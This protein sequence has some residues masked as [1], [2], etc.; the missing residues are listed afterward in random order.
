[1]RPSAGRSANGSRPPRAGSRRQAALASRKPSRVEALTLLC[2]TLRQTID[3]ARATTLE[4]LTRRIAP[5]VSALLPGAEVFCDEKF[6]VGAVTRGTAQERFELLSDGT[7]E[8]IAVLAR[9][10]LADLLL[11][12]GRPAS[13]VLDDALAFSDPERIERMFDI[14]HRAAARMQIIV[15]TCRDDVFGRLGGRRLELVKPDDRSPVP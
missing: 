10:A 15:L 8:Q 12:A 9:I 13:I 5:L 1:M 3:R 14:L 2:A 6:Q 11:A 4:P 7:R